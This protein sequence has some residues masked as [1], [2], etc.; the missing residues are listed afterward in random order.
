[1][2][3]NNLLVVNESCVEKKKKNWETRKLLYTLYNA[4]NNNVTNGKS[5]TRREYI[6]YFCEI[7]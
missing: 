1:M 6:L 4:F 3:V 2:D 7:F 5:I